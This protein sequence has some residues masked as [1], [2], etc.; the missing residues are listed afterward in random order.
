MNLAMRNTADVIS[1]KLICSP[2]QVHVLF[3]LADGIAL[4]CTK[5]H[6]RT[7]HEQNKSYDNVFLSPLLTI[8]VK[9]LGLEHQETYSRLL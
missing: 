4:F 5:H 7:S 1:G 8:V 2:S 6:M 3:P 9:S